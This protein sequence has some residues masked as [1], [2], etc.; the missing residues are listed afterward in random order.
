[1]K[2][3]GFLVI[4]ISGWYISKSYITS[5]YLTEPW[6]DDNK[7]FELS[8]WSGSFSPMWLA[9]PSQQHLHLVIRNLMR[10]IQ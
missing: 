2:N 3:V 7:P 6:D 4:N 8:G 9:L 5:L 10:M 1:M